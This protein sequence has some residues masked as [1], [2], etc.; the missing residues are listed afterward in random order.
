[1]PNIIAE[2]TV[3]ELRNHANDL[4]SNRMPEVT[5]YEIAER[6]RRDQGIPIEIRRSFYREERF[7]DPEGP[8]SQFVNRI[9]DVNNDQIRTIYEKLIEHMEYLNV[10]PPAQYPL[11]GPPPPPRPLMGAFDPLPNA[12]QMIIIGGKKK[13]RKIKR[14]RRSYKY[15]RKNIKIRFN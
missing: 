1:M 2:P 3:N 11:N 15:Q 10:N 9:G 7:G 5:F 8:L 6:F 13:T 14:S 4:Y 12:N